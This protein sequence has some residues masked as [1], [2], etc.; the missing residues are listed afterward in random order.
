M[1]FATNI[2]VMHRDY[3][4]LAMGARGYLP[5]LLRDCTIGIESSE[6]LDELLATRGAIHD[7]ERRYYTATSNDLADACRAVRSS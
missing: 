3:G 1:G 4:I 5:I 6:T 7:V 2:C